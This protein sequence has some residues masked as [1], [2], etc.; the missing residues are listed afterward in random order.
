MGNFRVSP[1]QAFAE[2]RADACLSAVIPDWRKINPADINLWTYTQ[3]DA[4]QILAG[5]LPATR[6]V[7]QPNGGYPS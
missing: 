4:E 1:R 2:N 7:D 5:A 3:R 6:S